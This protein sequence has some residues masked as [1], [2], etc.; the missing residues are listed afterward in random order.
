[1]QIN[2]FVLVWIVFDMYC[3]ATL[4]SLDYY[5]MILTCNMRRICL[6]FQSTCCFVG[7]HTASGL[8][9]FVWSLASLIF[10]FIF[11]CNFFLFCLPH[12][13]CRLSQFY[14][15]MFK[16]RFGILTYM[17]NLTADALVFFYIFSLY[18][19][20]ILAVLTFLL[21]TLLVKKG[22]F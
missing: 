9:L 11:M 5:Q 2:D 17:N 22:H 13:A 4:L 1:M 19:F 7:V 8:V 14:V 18:V 21:T 6:P 10:F 12:C 20:C 15:F 3:K 16:P